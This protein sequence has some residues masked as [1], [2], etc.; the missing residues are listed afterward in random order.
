MI[1]YFNL[2]PCRFRLGARAS[3]SAVKSRSGR[4]GLFGRLE[5][6]GPLA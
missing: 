5:R 4:K 2:L 1:F 3:G 6:L